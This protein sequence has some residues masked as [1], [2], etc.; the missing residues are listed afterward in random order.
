MGSLISNEKHVYW[1]RQIKLWEESGLSQA[2][3][4]EGQ[5]I[6]LATF[7]YYRHLFLKSAP[8]SPPLNFVAVESKPTNSPQSVAA[9]QLMLPNGIRVGVSSDATEPLLKMVLTVA[10]QVV[11]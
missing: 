6:K 11:C 9:L 4:C 2:S 3:Y 8:K 5:G 1:K 7:T 10:G